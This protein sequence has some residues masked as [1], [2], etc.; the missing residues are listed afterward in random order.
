MKKVLLTLLI[1]CL[2]V[3]FVSCDSPSAPESKVYVPSFQLNP[4][5]KDIGFNKLVEYFD[6][7][8]MNANNALVSSMRLPSLIG[9]SSKT[10]SEALAGFTQ[11][12]LGKI[13]TVSCT[14][15]SNGN[16]IFEG[17]TTDDSIYIKTVVK[18]DNTVD[19]L[20]MKKIN[21]EGIPAKIIVATVGTFEIDPN[22]DYQIGTVSAYVAD[23]TGSYEYFNVVGTAQIYLSNTVTASAID[24]SEGYAYDGIPNFDSY[25]SEKMNYESVGNYI[26]A[27]KAITTHYP[28]SGFNLTFHLLEKSLYAQNIYKDS[29]GNYVL[30]ESAGQSNV[31]V[32]NWDDMQGYATFLTN[33]KWVLKH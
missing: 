26:N 8:V 32:E 20:E 4:N 11:T 28:G 17:T 23:N 5:S 19:Y 27:V 10:N 13:V 16:Y 25:Y 30:P 2:L 31:P 18:T 3:F 22:K 29:D 21:V 15:D 6:N 9:F 1:V 14:K 7:D 33:G 12:V 24:M